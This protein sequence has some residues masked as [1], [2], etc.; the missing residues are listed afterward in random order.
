MRSLTEF[1]FP[2]FNVPMISLQDLPLEIQ[3]NGP[4]LLGH[5]DATSGGRGWWDSPWFLLL[6][7]GAILEHVLCE[8]GR[9]FLC[10]KLLI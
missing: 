6:A 10:V 9:L 8:R 1:F 3:C 5:N 7:H 2:T 4:Q